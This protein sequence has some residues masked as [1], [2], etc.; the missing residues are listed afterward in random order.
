MKLDTAKLKFMNPA[1]LLMGSLNHGSVCICLA[2]M[3]QVDRVETWITTRWY[4]FEHK[5]WSDLEPISPTTDSVRD[6][7]NEIS[8][9]NLCKE[10]QDLMDDCAGFLRDWFAEREDITSVSRELLADLLFPR[11]SKLSGSIKASMDGQMCYERHSIAMQALKASSIL[12]H[13]DVAGSLSWPDLC[14]CA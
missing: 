9:F 14:V 4:Y 6:F 7:V 11:G 2:K 12:H 3:L 5:F 8:K 1:V 13:H 10:L